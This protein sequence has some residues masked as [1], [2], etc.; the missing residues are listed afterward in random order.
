MSVAEI[1]KTVGFSFPSQYITAFKEK[2]G[3]TPNEYRKK[4]GEE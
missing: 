4:T 3:C 2:Y 1:T